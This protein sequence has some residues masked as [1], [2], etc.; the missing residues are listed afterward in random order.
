MERTILHCDCNGFYASVECILNPLLVDVPMAVAGNPDSRHGIILAKNELAKKYGIQTAETI[1]Q[2]R[3]KCPNLVLVPP[4]HHQYAK[5]S[6]LVNEIYGEFSDLVEP[7][8]IDESWLDVTGMYKILGSGSEI[9]DKIRATVKKKLGLTISVGVS[10]NKIFAKLGSDY[11][12]PDATTIISKN[13]YQSIVFPLPVN[14]LL[15]VGK[16]AT[17]T[18][19]RLNITTIGE[20]ANSKK[21]LIAGCL[22]KMGEMIWEYANGIEDSPVKPA[23]ESREIKSIGNGMTFKRNL[24]GIEDIR[25][26]INALADE[27]AWRMRKSGLKCETLQVTIKD[28]E[29][30]TISRQKKLA[31]PTHLAKELAQAALELVLSAWKLDVPVRMLTITAANLLSANSIPSQLEMFANSATLAKEKQEKLESTMDTIRSKYGKGAITMA[32]I[33]QNDL[34]IHEYKAEE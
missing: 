34:G 12:K 24:L 15:Y 32:S 22:G 9:A 7:F 11:K 25:L 30:K 14:Q 31:V 29:L 6:R 28:V 33:M 1:W 27:V 26:G 18:L 21:E 17:V 3:K 19:A 2:A 20:L 4:Q 16:V 8:G 10:F 5:Y 13:N 23:G